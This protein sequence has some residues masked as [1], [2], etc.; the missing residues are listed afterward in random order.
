MLAINP[1]ILSRFLNSISQFVIILSVFLICVAGVLIFF[2]ENDY[3]QGISF[4]IMFI[5]VPAAWLSLMFFFIMGTSSII[6]I[7]FKSPTAFT[8]A[9]SLSPIGLLMSILVIIT[10]S[11]WGNLTWGTYWV[12]DA[13]L[14]SMLIL[15]FIYLGHNLLLFSFEHFQKADFAASILA[16]IGLV[17][18]PI[19]KF[20][21]DWWTT[22]H[23]GSSVFKIGGP[24]L[25]TDYLITLL[26]GFFALFLLCFYW[27]ASI[28]Y[29]IIENRKIERAKLF[30]D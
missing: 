30:N 28:F 14:T 10:G 26:I 21:V 3:Y 7:V 24:S 27:F 12:W 9:R 1:N 2:L 16:I 15:A 13:R 6:G 8:I 19:V 23:Q 11:I 18:L 17:N 5:H 29:I 22:L 25:T 20:S 4:K